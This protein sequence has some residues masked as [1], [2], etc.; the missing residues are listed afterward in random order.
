MVGAVDR[1]GIVGPVIGAL[2]HEEGRH[3]LGG[4]A[5]G[6][7]VVHGRHAAPLAEGHPHPLDRGRAEAVEEG[8]V[9]TGEDQLDRLAQGLGGQGRGH[10]IVAVQSPAESPAQQVGLHDDAGLRPAQG[11]GQGRQ[12]QGLPLV[13]GV[14]LEDAVPLESQGVQ[15]LHLEVQ[16]GVC[17]VLRLQLGLRA[18]KGGVNARVVHHQGASGRV[19][20]Q[21]PA[22]RL[23]VGVRD[24]FRW[25]VF[26]GHLEGPDRAVSGDEAVTE[27]NHPTRHGPGRVVEDEMAAIARDAPGT[28]FVDRDHLGL[29]PRRRDDG[30]GVDHARH[31]RIQAEHRRPIGLGRDVT[32]LEFPADQAPF[33][34]WLDG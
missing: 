27:G 13:A 19:G 11:L 29:I 7:G 8:V 33:R 21:G 1:E 34:G 2:G 10:R 6:G 3:D 15:G 5:G 25:T 23:K 28:G 4:P 16:G 24:L 14:D 17:G 26:P 22:P 20:D 9:L 32:G 31:F 18:R 30:P 12:D